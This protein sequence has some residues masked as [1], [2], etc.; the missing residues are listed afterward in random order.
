MLSFSESS[1][2]TTIIPPSPDLQP[3]IDKMADYVARNGPEF[4]LVVGRKND[5]RFSFIKPENIHFAYYEYKK[6]M[7]IK[8]RT[9][10][11]VDVEFMTRPTNHVL[12]FYIYI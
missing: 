7:F 6:N 5:E 1:S 11:L 3:I 4:E 8:V 2:G 9:L 12:L 10:L